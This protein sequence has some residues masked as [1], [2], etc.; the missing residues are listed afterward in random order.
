MEVVISIS[1]IVRIVTFTNDSYVAYPN[2][3]SHTGGAISFSNG[4][5]ALE[6]KKQKLNV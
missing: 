4:I 6:S 1:N 3:R 2:V 5:F